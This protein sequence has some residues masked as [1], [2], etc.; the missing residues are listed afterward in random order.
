MLA[1]QVDRTVRCSIVEK[2]LEVL[3]GLI[4]HFGTSWEKVVFIGGERGFDVI[5][6]GNER[7]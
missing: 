1:E 2:P 4:S 6:S 5:G 3:R 7:F